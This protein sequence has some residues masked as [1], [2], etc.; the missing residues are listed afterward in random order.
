MLSLDLLTPL[1]W[2]FVIIDSAICV[3]ALVNCTITYRRGAR[4]TKCDPV[5]LQ[6]FIDSAPMHL[7]NP[8]DE[9]SDGRPVDVDPRTAAD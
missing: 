8:P 6:Q 7:L 4:P 1:E 3:G 5:R 9:L 2:F